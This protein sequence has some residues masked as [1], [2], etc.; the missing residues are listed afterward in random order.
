MAA[1]KGVRSPVRTEPHP[2]AGDSTARPNGYCP[3]AERSSET[4]QP[5]RQVFTGPRPRHRES[6]Y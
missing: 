4:M 5:D 6:R 3:S 1:I 2:S